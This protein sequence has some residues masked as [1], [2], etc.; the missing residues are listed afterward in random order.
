MPIGW[1]T[2]YCLQQG[3]SY[4]TCSPDTPCIQ[5]QSYPLFNKWASVLPKKSVTTIHFYIASKL[6][7]SEK[8]SIDLLTIFLNYLLL[9]WQKSKLQ[10]IKKASNES[11]V[12]LFIKLEIKKLPRPVPDS[13]RLHSCKARNVENAEKK[14]GWTKATQ[15]EAFKAYGNVKI[16]CNFWVSATLFLFFYFFN[17]H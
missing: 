11:Y 7:T 17:A 15:K 9:A 1:S 10:L 13:H 8:L 5:T 4:P 6:E 3:R 12:S 14:R 2:G 16:K